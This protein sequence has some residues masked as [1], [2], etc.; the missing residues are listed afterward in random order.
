MGKLEGCSGLREPL[1]AVGKR[2]PVLGDDDD[3]LVLK[4]LE[5]VSGGSLSGAEAQTFGGLDQNFLPGKLGTTL[6][7][8][9]ELPGLVLALLGGLDDHGLDLLNRLGDSCLERSL[10]GISLGFV[11]FV[12][13]EPHLFGEVGGG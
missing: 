6:I 13:D 5:Y 10:A 11:D 7:R 8:K 12:G 2:W 1:G 9:V 4:V 3:E